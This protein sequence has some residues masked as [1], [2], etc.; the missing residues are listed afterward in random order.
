MVKPGILIVAD[1]ASLRATVARWLIQ[2][3]YA[4]ELAESPKRAHEVVAKAT[5]A[6]A[7]VAPQGSGIELAHKLEDAVEHVMFFGTPDNIAAAGE[8]PVSSDLCITLPLS[9]QDVL[10]KVK[11]VLRPVAAREAPSTPQL[12]RFEG[13]TLDAGARTCLDARGKEM[14]LTRAE[15]SLLLA[16][17]QNPGRVLSRDELTRVVTG[18]GAEPEDRSVDVLISRLRRKI[19]TDPKTPRLVV[20]VPGEGYRF[21]ARPQAIIAP[22]QPATAQSA[23]VQASDAPAPPFDRQRSN[24]LPVFAVAAA[25]AVVL[26]MTVVGWKEWSNREA[27]KRDA[28]SPTLA[29]SPDLRPSP[30]P[31]QST[32][33]REEQRATV[34]KRMVAA[35]QDNQYTWRTVERLAI[36][37]GVDESEAHEILAEHPNEVVLGKS[38]E[39]KLLAKLA[40]RSGAASDLK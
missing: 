32:T 11:S 5:I 3:G 39:G 21:T 20:T 28:Q 40:G 25:L 37:S 14:T 6:L 9:E 7:I 18:R 8:P 27:L 12:L 36:L 10:A 23:A 24:R 1:D 33:S 15:F 38:Q 31:S 29:A 26:V 17:A 30:T 22:D 19:E 16:F 35:L 4:V 2:A 34:Y 13:Y